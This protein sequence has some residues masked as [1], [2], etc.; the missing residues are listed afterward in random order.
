MKCMKN[1]LSNSIPVAGDRVVAGET[2]EAC[3]GRAEIFSFCYFFSHQF[4][5]WLSSSQ[6]FL[7]IIIAFQSRILCHR[8]YFV[9]FCSEVL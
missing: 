2:H 8:T 6:Q 3:F 5:K 7:N 1:K 4:H 9:F